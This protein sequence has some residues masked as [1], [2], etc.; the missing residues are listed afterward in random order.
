MGTKNFLS[1]LLLTALAVPTVRAGW[2]DRF[3]GDKTKAV[4]GLMMSVLVSKVLCPTF[5]GDDDQVNAIRMILGLGG[6][7][8]C[9]GN[10]ASSFGQK[11]CANVFKK[12]GIKQSAMMAVATGLVANLAVKKSITTY[13]KAPVGIFLYAIMNE[14]IDKVKRRTA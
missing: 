7:S 5:V 12:F 3:G 11:R 14:G 8:V 10:I 1:L 13:W 4:G 2:R 6:A 9:A